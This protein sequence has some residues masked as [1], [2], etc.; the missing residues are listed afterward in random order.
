M[1]SPLTE[2][3]AKITTK[4]IDMM[5]AS[6]T[7]YMFIATALSDD[8][9]THYP[10]EFLNSIVT[11]G[12][13]SHKLNIKICMPVMVLRSLNLPRLMNGTRC[14]V[15]KSLRKVIEVKLLLG[16]SKMRLISYH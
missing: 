6:L 3:V 15:T 9:A 5:L 12:L 14:I 11:S 7:L 2:L 10:P 4:L 8:E 13:P 16:D 1:L